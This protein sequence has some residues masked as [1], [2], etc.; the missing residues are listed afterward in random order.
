[1]EE[2]YQRALELSFTYGY[3]R[4]VLKHNICEDQLEIP[5]C[6][7][8]SPNFLSP[9]FFASLRCP[10]ILAS[11]EDAAAG[12]HRREV[13]EESSR[14][15]TLGDLNGHP[16]SFF[17]FFFCN[18]PNVATLILPHFSEVASIWPL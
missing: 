10:P 18:G 6:T 4:C 15:A 14:G 13:A 7:P 12:V 11:Y 9:E 17:P 5:D 8:D 3:G 16:L 2:D 1:M